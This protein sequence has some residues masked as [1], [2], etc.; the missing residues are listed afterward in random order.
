MITVLVDDSIWRSVQWVDLH[1]IRLGGRHG[2]NSSRRRAM[3]PDAR[4]VSDTGHLFGSRKAH[5]SMFSEWRA[6]GRT[7]WVSQ[8]VSGPG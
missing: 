6:V 3:D 7:I 5:K 8:S 4:L 1:N 2:P